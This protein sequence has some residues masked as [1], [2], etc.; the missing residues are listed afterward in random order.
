MSGE[1]V[2]VLG[3]GSQG[4]LSALMLRNRGHA[5]TLID[6]APAPLLRAGLRNEGKIHLGF[7][8]VNDPSFDTPRLMLRSA[9][10]FAPRSKNASEDRL[11]GIVL[12]PARSP[13]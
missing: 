11:T 12:S 1:R 5:V 4:V 2:V 9:L 6:K 3:A 13:T 7:I 10:A 8:Y